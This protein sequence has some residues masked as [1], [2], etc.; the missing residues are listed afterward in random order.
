MQ[1]D[2]K[3]AHVKVFCYSATKRH[4][5]YTCILQVPGY[6]V[7]LQD[8]KR[9][10]VTIISLLSVF[11]DS[12]SN[13]I[14]KIHLLDKLNMLNT[15]PA[16]WNCPSIY[17]KRKQQKILQGNI[18]TQILKPENKKNQIKL[19][20]RTLKSTTC[21]QFMQSPNFMVSSRTLPMK[22]EDERKHYYYSLH[23][24]VRYAPMRNRYICCIHHKP[25]GEAES[26]EYWHCCC[27]AITLS[28]T[29]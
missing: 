4:Y 12:S 19:F 25:Y 27:P 18:I 1:N 2:K 7:Y 17:K 24:I 16:L 20:L 8:D 11:I 14:T 21:I 26:L 3:M 29:L 5:S 10:L 28:P 23:M 22:L 6:N 13:S 9:S 15:K